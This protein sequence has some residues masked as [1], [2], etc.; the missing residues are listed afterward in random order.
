MTELLAPQALNSLSVDELSRLRSRLHSRRRDTEDAIR[1]SKADL[2]TINANI[3][4][5][6]DTIT[7][8]TASKPI[9]VSD[10]AVLRYLGL[11]RK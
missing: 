6:N 2:Q 8:K 7:A 3:K 1:A 5:V 11:V 4:A 9:A 10:H